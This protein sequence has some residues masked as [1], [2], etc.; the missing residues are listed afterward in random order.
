MLIDQLTQFFTSPMWVKFIVLIFLMVLVSFVERNK[1]P[2]RFRIFHRILAILVVRD[3]VYIFIPMATVMVISDVMVFWVYLAWFRQ[4]KGSLEQDKILA[5]ISAVFVLLLLANS[6]FGFISSG[7]SRL[8]AIIVIGHY[9]YL[10]VHTYAISEFNTRRSEIIIE[11]RHTLIYYPILVNIFFVL[12]DYTPTFVQYL[13]VPFGYVMHYIMLLRFQNRFEIETKEEID[14]LQN[15]IS[16]ILDF[17][18]SI[19]QA[20]SARMNMEDILRTVVQSASQNTN[21]DGGAIL[22]VEEDDQGRPVLS[23]KATY[24]IYCPPLPMSDVIKTKLEAIR[25]NFESMKIPIP[26]TVLGE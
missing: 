8:A 25:R 24:G 15:D 11:T 4:T 19:G 20:I 3:L 5:G 23:P 7:W 12:F 18:K 26:E 10:A 14:F 16:T 9:I 6:V 17:M 21:A 1:G 22:L 13:V 2:E